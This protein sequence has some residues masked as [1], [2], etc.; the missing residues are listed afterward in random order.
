[1]ETKKNEIKPQPG[2]QWMFASCK[3]D[4]CIYGGAAFGGK[5]FGLL[6][7]SL[8][9]IGHPRYNG[10]IFRRTSPQITA[11][12]G[13]WDTAS[14]IYPKFGG[15]GRVQG[16]TYKF[17]SGA[18]IK[19]SH[20]Q[21]DSDVLAHQGAQYPFIGF[22]ELTHFTR[23]QF[24]YLLSRNRPA[25]GCGNI[26]PYVRCTTNPDAD[27]WVREFIDWWIGEDGYPIDARCGVVRYF[28]IDRGDVV[29]VDSDWRD[30]DGS[31]PKSFTFIGATIED[32]VIGQEQDPKYRSNLNAQGVVDRERLLKG[33][34]NISYTGGMFNPKWFRIVEP[35]DVPLGIQWIRY[36]DRASTVPTDQ[37]KEPDWTAGAKV[38]MHN[39]TLYI[40]DMVHFRDTPAVNEAMI[41]QTAEDDGRDTPVYIE[42]EGGS[43]GKDVGYSY[44]TKVLSGFEVHLDRPTGDKIDRAKPWCA[45]A[46]HGNVVLVKGAWNRAFLAEAG[47]FPL[48][49]KDQIDAVSGGWKN[50]IGDFKV[51]DSYRASNRAPFTIDFQNIKEGTFDVFCGL[52]SDKQGGVYGNWY[53]WKRDTRVLFVYSEIHNPT[54]IPD[55]LVAAVRSAACVTNSRITKVFGCEE[56]FSSGNSMMSVFRK[57]GLVLKRTQDYNEAAAIVMAR[58]MFVNGM[59][60]VDVNNCKDTDLEYRMWPTDGRVPEP[61]YFHCRALCMVVWSLRN[62]GKT[63]A[64]R[65]LSP[66]SKEKV[67]VRNLLRG[68]YVTKNTEKTEYDYLLR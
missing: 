36:W 45:L 55:A 48:N 22:D 68:G 56:M 61:G 17:P 5:S 21:Y 51:W 18:Y 62:M 14:Q 53:L 38:G 26:R 12:G 59:I 42:Q 30:A 13:L 44:Q 50:I 37:N 25:T 43:S 35:A 9:N 11:G 2:K 10:V 27:S 66:Y 34:W 32:N 65:V 46:E 33:N 63:A 54:P 58:S 28:T 67:R 24:F 15:E 29:W 1:M 31:E 40:G 7:E 16:L 64:P 8:R 49:K 6:L 60:R 4:I 39:G 57:R 20:L 47:S 19:F 3:A 41:R 52:C 23:K